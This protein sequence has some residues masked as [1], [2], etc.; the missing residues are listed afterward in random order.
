MVFGFFQLQLALVSGICQC[1]PISILQLGSYLSLHSTFPS[2]PSLP[3]TTHMPQLCVLT[4]DLV[5]TVKG[6][7]T[8]PQLIPNCISDFPALQKP[9][10]L[11]L[12]TWV[13]ATHHSV[14]PIFYSLLGFPKL[15]LVD[16]L[17]KVVYFPIVRNI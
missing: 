7:R 10:W 2:I 17:D 4:R 9:S 6:Y 12:P 15:G 14:W 3:N 8:I 16:F 1:C 5:A 11:F 13:P